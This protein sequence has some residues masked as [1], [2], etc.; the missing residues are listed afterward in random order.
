M[1]LLRV[2]QERT[3]DPVGAVQSKPVDVR[4]IAATHKDL[5]LLIKEINFDKIYSTDSIYCL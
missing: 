3:I 5:E 4:V 1:K 2:L